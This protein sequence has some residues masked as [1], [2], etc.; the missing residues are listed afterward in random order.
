MNE[1]TVTTR[2]CDT[3]GCS[4]PVPHPGHRYCS[5]CI[6]TVLRTARPPELL[7]TWRRRIEDPAGT[8]ATMGLN[9]KDLTGAVAA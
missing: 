4:N 9:G 7:P 1:L 2:P 5:D 3:P 6:G 8:G